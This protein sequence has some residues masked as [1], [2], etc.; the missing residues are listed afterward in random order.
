DYGFI[1][2]KD[3]GCPAFGFLFM[4]ILGELNMVCNKAFG[5][6]VFLYIFLFTTWYVYVFE[7]ENGLGICKGGIQT[8]VFDLFF[9][10]DVTFGIHICN[11]NI[12]FVQHVWNIGFQTNGSCWS[13][14]II[15]KF[16]FIF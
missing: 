4:K 5:G 12:R 1:F 11:L 2:I 3:N 7:G 10:S 14:A 16:D 13:F 15:F 9:W 6:I 8:T